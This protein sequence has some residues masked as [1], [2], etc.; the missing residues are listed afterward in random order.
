MAAGAGAAV[1]VAGRR[2][3]TTLDPGSTLS[4]L[5]SSGAK[6]S[7]VLG[8]GLEQQQQLD[9]PQ[10]PRFPLSDC[11]WRALWY[12]VDHWLEVRVT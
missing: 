8:L 10:F 5:T 6:M 11:D 1:A 12:L 3:A 2:R 4:R 9:E 7:E